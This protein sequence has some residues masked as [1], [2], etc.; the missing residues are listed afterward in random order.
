M[1]MFEQPVDQRYGIATELCGIVWLPDRMA[2]DKMVVD[3]AEFDRVGL[4]G[5]D[6]ELTEKL[7]GISG[8]YL[9]FQF[10]C[11]PDRDSRFSNCCWPGDHNK[12]PVRFDIRQI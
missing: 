10:F 3:L 1:V 2:V 4:G 11:Q 9:C 7:P 8:Y 5:S 12:F 6:V